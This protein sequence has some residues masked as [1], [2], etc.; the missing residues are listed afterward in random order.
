MLREVTTPAPDEVIEI[1]KA[2]NID[3][4]PDAIRSFYLHWTFDSI[5]AKFDRNSYREEGRIEGFAEGRAEG[6][7]EMFDVIMKSIKISG[8]ADL[9]PEQIAQCREYVN[10]TLAGSELNHA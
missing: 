2:R 7:Q 8:L 4:T 5:R 3:P 10:N 6:H 1:L 9:T